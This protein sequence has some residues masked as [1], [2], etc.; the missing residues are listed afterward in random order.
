MQGEGAVMGRLVPYHSRL[1]Y[2]GNGRYEFI[3]AAHGE[4]DFRI[5]GN[6]GYESKPLVR[7]AAVELA[8]RF[9]D[10]GRGGG[11]VYRVAWHPQNRDNE[12]PELIGPTREL[13]EATG[14][15]YVI[16]NVE[17]APLREPTMF[18]G[19]G[20]GLPI[21]RHRIFESTFPLMSP[22]CAHG[23]L[24]KRFKVWRHG[25]E[26]DSAFVPVYGTGGGKA[27]EHWAEAMGI[28]WMTRAE[29]AQAIPPAYTKHI[30]EYLL[31]HIEAEK[32][33]AA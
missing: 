31:R 11:E 2:L 10:S 27:A 30:G 17:G 21:Q 19:S 24:A 9:T 14:L 3:E 7:E 23:A 18:C 29:M 32:A 33:V 15:P 6:K 8:T 12:Y 22:G 1:R 5:V 28:D 4:P 20:F 26:I 25:R 13:L 16:E